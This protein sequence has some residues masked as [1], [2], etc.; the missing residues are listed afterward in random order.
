[1][2]RNFQVHQQKM[3]GLSLCPFN[4]HIHDIAYLKFVDNYMEQVLLHVRDIRFLKLILWKIVS[5]I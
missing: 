1:M 2:S 4:F 3:S 5:I